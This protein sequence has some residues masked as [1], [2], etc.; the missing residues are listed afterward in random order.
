MFRINRLLPWA[1]PNYVSELKCSARLPI[2]QSTLHGIRLGEYY[3]QRHGLS[4]VSHYI[5]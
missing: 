3:R 4:H 5:T 1:K 2:A